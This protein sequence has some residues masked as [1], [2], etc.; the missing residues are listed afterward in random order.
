[1]S[2]APRTELYGLALDRIT[3]GEAV[4]TVLRG[5]AEGRGGYVVATNLDVL[6]QVAS[7]R[8]LGAVLQDA[9]LVVADGMPLIWA[10][11]LLGTRLPERVAGSDLVWS[12]TAEA[13]LRDHTVYMLG[14]APG[15]AEAACERLHGVYPGA[16]IVGHHCPPMGFEQ[17][18]AEIARIVDALRSARP[19]I[20]YVA[21]GFPKQ[22][23]LIA[24]LRTQLPQ[25]WFLAVGASLSF[26][27]G[28][29]RRAPP[30]MGRLGLEWVHRLA[31]E[32]RRLARR[33]LV[34]DVP[35]ALRLFA[36]CLCSGALRRLRA[37]GEPAAVEVG[38]PTRPTERVV[39]GSGAL[40]RER[41][42]LL[43][44]LMAYENGASGANGN[45]RSAPA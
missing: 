4:S 22:E 34:D 7:Q 9:D 39:F 1:M 38:P 15:I 29:V 41:A 10:S 13:A 27:A 40:E 37:R 18:E 8:E 45:K 20:V 30:W 14:G 26:V 12:L 16:R 44:E 5:V 28:H 11:R 31:Q 19:D 3:E 21:L 23:R 33:Y 24:Y 25:V 32:P 43:D 42:R 17:D 36:R 6:R 35:F 2:P